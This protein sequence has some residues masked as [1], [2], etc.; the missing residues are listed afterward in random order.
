MQRAFLPIALVLGLAACAGPAEKVRYAPGEVPDYNRVGVASWYGPGFQ[1]RKTAS[2]VRFNMNALTA[3]HRSLPFGT[4][5]RVTNVDNGRTVVVT[6][7]DRGPFTRGRIIDLSKA[8]ASRLGMIKQGLAKVRV[9]AIGR[10]T[11]SS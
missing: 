4:Q 10:V 7:N 1:G 3:A 8:A 11:R 5:V 2:G 6:I 9:E